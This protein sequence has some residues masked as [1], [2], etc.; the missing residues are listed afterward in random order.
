MNNK[1][2]KLRH[3]KT[4]DGKN[5][6]KCLLW[7]VLSILLLLILTAAGAMVIRSGALSPNT[8]YSIAPIIRIVCAIFCGAI[9]AR[10]AQEYAVL[11]GIVAVIGYMIF[12]ILTAVVGSVSFGETIASA[13]SALCS[14]ALVAFLAGRKNGIR[15][16][17]GT[18]RKFY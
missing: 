2:G 11:R 18:I 17:R 14:G 16:S 7:S 15:R 10:T 9:A 3:M 12:L 6:F 1:N 8:A 5:W 4:T 13:L